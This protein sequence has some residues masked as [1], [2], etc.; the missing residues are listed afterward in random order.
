M[1]DVS[2]GLAKDLRALAPRGLAPAVYA[3]LLPRRDGATVAEALG[4]GE[5]YEL[6]F[7]VAGKTRRSRFEAAW[8]RAFPRVRLTWIGRLVGAGTVPPDALALGDFHGYE[9]LR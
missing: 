2:D 1:M 9:H 6:V 8:R 7:C 5:D 3:P 4:D